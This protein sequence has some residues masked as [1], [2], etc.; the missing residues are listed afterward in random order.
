MKYIKTLTIQ[1][2]PYKGRNLHIKIGKPIPYGAN[3][4]S[5]GINFSIMSKNAKRLC[6]VISTMEEHQAIIEIPFDPRIHKSGDVWHM[7][8]VNLPPDFC[9]TY[10][11]S[12][13]FDPANGHF[14][15]SQIHLLDPYAKAI[16]GDEKW[17]SV[18]IQAGDAYDE[19]YA[20]LRCFIPETEFDW[21]DDSP[22]NRPL[23]D[24]IIYELH[25]RGFTQHPSSK[26]TNPGTF[27]GIIEKIP[28]LKKLGITA[29]EL[30]PINEFD[31]NECMFTNPITGEK[32]KNY[33]GYSTISFFA[34]NAAY[35]A[36]SGQKA[37]VAE[38]KEMVKALHEAGIEVIIDIVFNHTAEG[39][40]AGP[41]ISFRGLDNTIY[42]I[43]DRDFK[44]MNFSGCGNTLNCNHPVVREMILDCLRYWVTE[45]HVDGFRFDLASILGRDHT[46][47]VMS[48]P[49]VLE[50]IALDP[51]LSNSK[52]IAE[53]WDAAGLYQVGHFPAWK[54]WAEW[55]DKYRDAIRRFI[56]G[57]SGSVAE[58][59]TRI[60]G[61]SDLYGA[62]ERKP[63]HSIN[64][65]SCH[66]G[67]TLYDLV[68]YN[69]KHNQEN[70][71]GNRDG[72][73]N[74]LSWNCGVEGPTHKAAVTRL[75]ARQIKNFIALLMLSQG[76]PMILAG[77]E[78]CRTQKGN[79]NAYC[80]DNDISWIDWD[81]KDR[82]YDVFRFMCLMID[83]RRQYETLRRETFFTGTKPFEQ[84]L[85]DISW[86]GTK[87]DSPDFDDKSSA[88]AFLIS[89][90]TE[91]DKP[92]QHDIYVA[93]NPTHRQQ[94]FRIPDLVH[95]DWFLKVDTANNSPQ[96][97]YE[98]EHE[99]MLSNPRTYQLRSHSLLILI[100]K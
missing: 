20:Y 45:M 2:D 90:V 82:H 97:F 63:Y 50:A 52:I 3:E 21:G 85:P 15:N 6:L 51:I 91:N 70:G 80:Q 32:L 38:F 84:A 67:F 87:V 35:S 8:I 33:W 66:D 28:Y 26:V 27:R 36:S 53:A 72:H 1:K 5:D 11:V 73:N 71:E 14:F 100:A 44:Y 76:T 7:E 17:G 56:K 19:N 57:D 75:R 79:N 46:G 30:M 49:P 99:L 25:V 89:G 9:Y 24:T 86:H 16:N 88:L 13:T 37:Q 34:P 29:V 98:D 22:I 60:A 43:L 62:S 83:F 93:V 74:N 58:M 59:S 96:D 23:K 31:E 54:R 48:N 64:Y 81:L 18:P 78:F 55:N 77:D 4:S 47:A 69:E 61:S 68:A 12:G 65:V 41:T 39:T 95:R 92:K 40:E 42:Y 94:T 10:H